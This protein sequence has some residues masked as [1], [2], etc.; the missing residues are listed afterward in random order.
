LKAKGFEVE[1][2]RSSAS[3]SKKIRNAQLSQFN[4]IVVAGEDE[5][6]NNTVSVRERSGKNLGSFTIS[7]FVDLMVAEYPENVPLPV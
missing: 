2:D 3:L 6:N 7:Q 4:Y 1:L 5:K